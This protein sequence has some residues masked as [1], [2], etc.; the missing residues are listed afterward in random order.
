MAST[1]KKVFDRHQ[2]TTAWIIGASALVAGVRI[3]G[4]RRRRRRGRRTRLAVLVRGA[5]VQTAGI[6]QA[7]LPGHLELAVDQEAAARDDAL[8]VREPGDD[9]VVLARARAQGDL[10]RLEQAL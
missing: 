8:A 9:G 7:R 6:E 1:I 10:A 2:R 5:A 4:L 3:G